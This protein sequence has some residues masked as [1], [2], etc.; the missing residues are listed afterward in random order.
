MF[1]DFIYPPN[2]VLANILCDIEENCDTFDSFSKLIITK[3]NNE[4][5]IY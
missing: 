4:K 3:T 2:I 5:Q 1:M